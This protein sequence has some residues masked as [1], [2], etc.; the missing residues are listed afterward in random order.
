MYCVLAGARENGCATP[1]W[2]GEPLPEDLTSVPAMKLRVFDLWDE[3]D[4]SIT[5]GFAGRSLAIGDT[6]IKC[7]SPLNVLKDTYDRSC[8]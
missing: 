6:I 4:G 2:L 7:T 5:R 3:L 1:A 8:Y